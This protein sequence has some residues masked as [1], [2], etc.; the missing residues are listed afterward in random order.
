[1]SAARVLATALL[2]CLYPPVCGACP[3]VGRA[4]LCRICR[5][6]ALFAPPVE[7]EGLVAV[8]A[9]Y[10]YGAAVAAAIQA[11]KYHGRPELG[12]AFGRELAAFALCADLVVPVPSTASRLAK[13]GYN[14]SRE[15][16][17]GLGMPVSTLALRRRGEPEPQVHLSRRSRQVAPRGTF[18]AAPELVSGRR[19]LVVDDVITTGG[20]LSAVAEALSSAGAREVYAVA[21]AHAPNALPKRGGEPSG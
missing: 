10:E 13:R 18:V 15:L 19:I 14:P 5:E 8:H 9:L 6:S 4:P 20:T 3:A 2:D 1:M 21:V 17:R 7:V 12:V 11:L 16:A